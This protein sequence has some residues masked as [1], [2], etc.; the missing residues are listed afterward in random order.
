MKIGKIAIVLGVVLV[1]AIISIVVVT[2]SQN[3]MNEL[4]FSEIAI[5]KVS[6]SDDTIQ[7]S[8][9]L[10]S[11]AKTYRKYSYHVEDDNL[12]LTIKGGLVTKKYPASDLNITI[13]DKNAKSI[14]K[15]YLKYSN[16]VTLIGSR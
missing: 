1:I 13:Q 4:H 16:E 14:N 12:Y 5:Q 9:D 2:M 8:G 7:I 3:K 10:V 15:V 6:F 11:S